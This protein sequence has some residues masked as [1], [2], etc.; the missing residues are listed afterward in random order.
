VSPGKDS[1]AES[2]VKPKTTSPEKVSFAESM[3]LKGLTI[4]P[5]KSPSFIGVRKLQKS[6]SRRKFDPNGEEFQF[7]SILEAP[8]SRMTADE[9]KLENIREHMHDLFVS[10]S[11]ESLGV[12]IASLRRPASSHS[13][14][15]EANKI[16]KSLSTSRRASV[17]FAHYLVASDPEGHFNDKAPIIAT[18]T[19][20]IGVTIG[21]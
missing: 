14:R 2:D 11:T 10:K 20:G 6:P 9:E 4:D 18:S 13:W 5:P 1:H 12:S 19:V 16:N 7:R 8:K 3:G 21:R 15:R 17:D